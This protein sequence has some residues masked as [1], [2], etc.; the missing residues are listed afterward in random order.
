MRARAFVRVFV[1]FHT[2]VRLRWT[3][4]SAS[5][6]AR[7]SNVDGACSLH[8][9]ARWPFALRRSNVRGVARQT[10]RAGQ[11]SRGADQTG[12]ASITDTGDSVGVISVRAK[13]DAVSS[14]LN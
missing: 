13:P 2:V 9:P 12:R 4:S 3:S 14:A 11:E 8:T 7:P 10:Q 6:R 5:G 1:R